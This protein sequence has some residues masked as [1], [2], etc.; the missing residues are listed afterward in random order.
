MGD[1]D[2]LL[3]KMIEAFDYASYISGVEWI[4]IVELEPVNLGY[5]LYMSGFKIEYGQP[6]VHIKHIKQMEINGKPILL[7]PDMDTWM[8]ATTLD[9]DLVSKGIDELYTNMR[10][11]TELH[12]LDLTYNK[13]VGDEYRTVTDSSIYASKRQA[14]RDA[15]MFRKKHP[16]T[17]KFTAVKLNSQGQ[18]LLE[19]KM[20]DLEFANAALE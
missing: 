11:S 20:T 2:L 1:R 16:C 7:T 19:H 18:L 10:K 6:L 8:N 5:R 12:V 9:F 17:F 4:Q 15:I 3:I 14:C 13:T